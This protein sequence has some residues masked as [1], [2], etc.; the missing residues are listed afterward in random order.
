MTQSHMIK[1]G[2]SLYSFQ[3]EFFLRKMTLEDCIAAC[4]RLG[5]KGIETIGEQ[6]MPG[7]SHQSTLIS[8]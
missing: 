4:A 2:V 5:A 1:R 7:L 3:E 8:L 6:M